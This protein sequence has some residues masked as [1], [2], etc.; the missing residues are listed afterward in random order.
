VG[1]GSAEGVELLGPGG[2]DDGADDAVGVLSGGVA[3]SGRERV[4]GEVFDASGDMFVEGG[5]V[6]FEILEVAAAGV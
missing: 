1:H 6:G 4:G 2:A 5:A 3:C